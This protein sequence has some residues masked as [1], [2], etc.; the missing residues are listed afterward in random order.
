MIDSDF[1]LTPRHV[2]AARALLAWKQTD[3]AR[4]ASVATSTIADFER[5]QRTPVAN[6]AAAIKEALEAQ[7][8][9]FLPGGAVVSSQVPTP[10][11]PKPGR[12]MRW[13]EAHDLAQWG[14]TRDGQAKL[15]ELASRLI[16][17]VYGPAAALRFP[18]DDSIQHAG[19]DGVCDAPSDSTYVPAGKS[20]WEMGAQRTGIGGKAQEEYDKRTANPLG[21][22]RS[23]SCFIFFTPQR[24]PQKE[25]WANERRA[26][27]VWRDVRVIDGDILVHWLELYPGVAEWLAV[28]INRRPKGLRNLGEVWSEWS[29]ATIPALSHELILADRDDQAISVLRWLNDPESVLSVQ[30]EAADEA[31]AFL[32]A[33]VGQFPLNHRVYWESRILAAQSDDIARELIGLGP[34]LIVVLNGGDPGVAAALVNDGHH[35]YV[36]F[37]SDVGSPGDVMRLPRPWRHTIGRELEA[38]GLSMLDARRFAGLCGRSLTV[39]RRI[40]TASPASRPAWTRS[41]VSPSL[42]AA[43]L[44]GAWREDH[45]ADRIILERLSGRSYDQLEADLAPLASSF[46][47]PVRRSGPVWKLASLRD[48][49]FLLGT[50]LTAH[51]LDLLE[52]CFLQV[53]GE[54]SPNFDADP[55]DQWKFDREPPKL[56]SNEVRRGLSET[57][58]ALGIFPHQASSVSDAE[59]RSARAVHRLLSGADER[60]WWSLSD[61]FRSLAEAAPADFLECVDNALDKVPSPI[62]SLFRSDEGFLHPS[63]YLA[64][65]LCALELLCWS[66]K[67]L[68]AGGLLLARLADIDPGGKLENRPR[69]SLQR[70]FLPWIPQTYATGEQRLRVLD[71]IMKRFD[72][73]GW[74]LLM[75]LAPTNFGTSFPSAVPNWRDY[76]EHDVEPITR[77]GIA[78]AYTAIGERLLAKAGQD[79]RRWGALLERWANFD[80]NW[81]VTAGERLAETVTHFAVNDRVTFREKLRA[82]IDKHEAFSDAYWAMDAAS[83][84]PLKAIFTSLE[85]LEVTAKHAWLFNR[86]NHHFRG[87]TSFADPQSFA[88]AQARV[89]AEQCSAVEEIAGVTS[90]DALINYARTLELPD[91]FGQAF[92]A[93]SISDAQKDEFLDLALRVEEPLIERLAQ[94]MIF[95]LA[96]ARGVDWLWE[97]FEQALQEGC[98]RR[99]ILP[100][101]FALP[102][103]QGTWDRI[104]AA[105]PELD[106]DYW[107]RVQ[108]FN[109]PRDEDFHVVVDKYLSVG[110]GRAAL[111]LIGAPRDIKVASADILRVLRDPSTIKADGDAIDPNNGV[112]LQYY[113][114]CAFKRLDAD[115][116]ISEEELVGLEWTY[117]NALQDSDRPARTLHKALSTQPKFF[118]Q[119]LSAVF[120]AKDDVAPDDP[121]A[122]EAARAIA[123][124]AFHV[125]EEWKRVP[126]SDDTGVIDGAA[127]KAWVKEARQLCAEAGRAD[128]GDSRIGRILSA[129]PRV[130]DEAWPPEPIREVIEGCRS[131]DLEQGFQIGL[132]NRRGV[133][134]RLP[135]DGGQQERELAAQYRVDALACFTWPRTQAV[136]E[137]I[138]QGYERDAAR[139]DQDAEQRDWM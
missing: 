49:W 31:I 63:E 78:R 127:L 48:A 125:L 43:M 77:Q 113:V 10:V 21:A 95:V 121:A 138:A 114:A 75:D 70:I 64:D 32:Y 33:A 133:T 76:S 107:L 72:R 90:P 91:D 22:N 23:E 139:E 18:S 79:P 71:A 52:Q 28:R 116:T 105:G 99:E 98:H 87:G 55:R 80:M 136:L 108:N 65:L 68:G 103:N 117:F 12:P 122:F 56:P 135:T 45:P 129:A 100:F 106:R 15:P 8:I 36:A 14:G 66:P 35:V 51:H 57:M 82:L 3:L 131:R 85:P 123:T 104:A 46:D 132:Y 112:M 20:V 11:V 115:E 124:Q 119:L 53:L 97:R 137:R 44:A 84:Q 5:G 1:A 24:W 4:A 101:A 25:V 27:G 109:I 126:G 130:P 16:L 96:G 47:G 83:L 128:V 9:R 74:N 120:P 30:A 62:A 42:I 41:I 50:H 73:I 94:R 13:I 81:R 34:K 88:D 92:A 7:G 58:I 6:N 134:V 59:S 29:L 19:W 61:D 93:S 69:G 102:V 67:H 40:L 39:L 37:G 110:R 86:G 118:V 89:L 60:L 111:E 2:R 54:P 38:M 17:A 26:E